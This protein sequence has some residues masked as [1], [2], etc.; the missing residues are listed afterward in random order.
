MQPVDRD[1]ERLVL[2]YLLTSDDDLDGA[3]K[4]VDG[5]DEVHLVAPEHR[6][7]FGGICRLVGDGIAVNTASVAEALHANGS[8]TPGHAEMLRWTLEAPASLEAALVAKRRLLEL[9]RWR[10]LLDL[11]DYYRRSFAKGGTT[12]DQLVGQSLAEL[13]AISRGRQTDVASMADVMRKR[14]AE[15]RAAEGKPVRRMRTGFAPLDNLVGGFG[16][17]D[18]VVLAGATGGGKTT[19]AE[20]VLTSVASTGRQVLVASAEMQAWELADRLL[21]RVSYVPAT[22]IRD[23]QVDSEQLRTLEKVANAEAW[24]RA[25]VIER[26]GALTVQ[27]IS[28]VA[29]DMQRRNGLGLIIVDYLQLISSLAAP[30]ERGRTRQA[31]VAA[32]ARG[33]KNMAMDLSVPV[34]ALSQFNREAAKGEAEPELHHLRESGEIEQAANMVLFLWQHDDDPEDIRR[35]ICKK[36]R[37]GAVNRYVSLRWSPKTL[38]FERA[39]S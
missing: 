10:V 4:V 1:A 24:Q 31:E 35:L 9:R 18:L 34:L 22:A 11:G 3:A 32:V 38:S 12:V 20:H 2:S 25:G 23:N 16:D 14:V 15:L 37:S 39:S 28:Q 19:L 36:H 33:L 5:L 26:N 21:S 6:N 13:E 29:R 8:V 17:S 27:R 30:G 7:A